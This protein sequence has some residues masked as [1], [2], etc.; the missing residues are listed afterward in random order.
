MNKKELRKIIAQKKK[1][2]SQE[3]LKEWSS[4]LLTKLETHPSFV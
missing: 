4:N 2:Y 1:S 3:Q